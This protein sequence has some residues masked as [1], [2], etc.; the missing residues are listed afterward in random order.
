VRATP[1]KA[2]RPASATTAR[3]ADPRPHAPQATAQVSAEAREQ[4]P[5]RRSRGGKRAASAAEQAEAF[6]AIELGGGGLPQVS[7][8]LMQRGAAADGSGP[9][10]KRR[11]L[12][13]GGRAT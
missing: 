10:A 5:A 9:S 6:L 1:V 12:G 4:S 2:L 3:P 7:A 8:R 13:N 11:G